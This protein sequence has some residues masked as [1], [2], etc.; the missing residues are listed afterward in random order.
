[1]KCQKCKSEFEP[2]KRNG[3]I[4]SKSCLKCLVKGGKKKRTIELKEQITN[5]KDLLQSKIQEIA[6]LIDHGQPCPSKKTLNCQFHGGHIYAKGG[7]YSNIRFNLHNIH[8]QSAQS[9]NYSA[10]EK[11]FYE[12]LKNEYGSDYMEFVEMIKR[13]SPTTKL[14]NEEYNL[15]YKI[16]CK[17]AN[18]LRKRLEVYNTTN[19][20]F[21]RNRINLNIGIYSYKESVYNIKTI[22]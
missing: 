17:E 8:R 19:R 20:L 18:M 13:E 16:A 7:Q 9:N 11:E 22:E 10:D 2:L 15:K 14:T 3:I 1:M 21:E 6:R 4:I 12:G 5:Y